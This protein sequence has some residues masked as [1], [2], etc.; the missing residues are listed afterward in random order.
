MQLLTL[1]RSRRVR[2]TARKRHE[3]SKRWSWTQPRIYVGA[4]GCRVKLRSTSSSGEL[5]AD[6]HNYGDRRWRE[7]TCRS[8]GSKK[9]RR[10]WAPEPNKIYVADWTFW[11]RTTSHL[12]WCRRMQSSATADRH[13]YGGNEL[14][15]VE[16]EGTEGV[17][18]GAKYWQINVWC[19]IYRLRF[20]LL[21]E[22]SCC[23]T[24]G[25]DGHHACCALQWCLFTTS[26]A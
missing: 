6:R 22:S 26:W 14:V 19:S 2:A 11:P 9:E 17:S 18:T 20:C 10:T 25:Y 7:R 8:L 3:S 24:L 23:W 13:N 5:P 15:G 1:D 12:H 4:V 21:F 16:R